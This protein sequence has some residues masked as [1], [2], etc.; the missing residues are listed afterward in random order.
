M[1][2]LA[3]EWQGKYELI[4]IIVNCAGVSGPF[5]AVWEVP[6]EQVN[7]TLDTNLKGT[8]NIARG[9]I[10]LMLRN[11]SKPQYFI[12]VSS[13]LGLVTEAHLFSYQM[14]KHGIV[15]FTE[16]LE[17][18]LHRIDASIQSAVFFPFFVKSNLAHSDRHLTH[19]QQDLYVALESEAFLKAIQRETEQGMEAVE[20]ANVL[21][22]GLEAGAFYIF[23]DRQTKQEFKVRV[24]HIFERSFPK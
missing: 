21:F 19:K 9:F 23:T 11:K 15:A 18:D 24:E 5:G 2:R 4:D 12:T 1:D 17:K 13:H 10:P 3:Q 6:A 14:A 16:V 8:V 22:D 7:W 20:A